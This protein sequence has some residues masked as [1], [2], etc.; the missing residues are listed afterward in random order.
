[1]DINTFDKNW[2]GFKEPASCQHYQTK[3]YG[4]T[5]VQFCTESEFLKMG[6]KE[7]TKFEYNAAKFDYIQPNVSV[8]VSIKDL[9]RRPKQ[10]YVLDVNNDRYEIAQRTLHEFA[11]HIAQNQK[12]GFQ[13]KP[14]NTTPELFVTPVSCEGLEEAVVK[15]YYN[16]IYVGPI[17]EYQYGFYLRLMCLCVDDEIFVEKPNRRTSTAKAK[18]NICRCAVLGC[19]AVIR[20][21]WAQF[22]NE[23]QLRVRKVNHSEEFAHSHDCRPAYRF[24]EELQSIPVP[25]KVKTY[26]QPKPEEFVHFS[27]DNLISEK[28][29][30]CPQT[31]F[32]F[33]RTNTTNVDGVTTTYYSCTKSDDDCPARCHTKTDGTGTL[34]AL[35]GGPHN[36][37]W[38]E[39]KQCVARFIRKRELEHHVVATHSDTKMYPCPQ[40]PKSYPSKKSLTKHQLGHAG[41]VECACGKTFKNKYNLAG[42]QKECKDAK[43]AKE[44]NEEI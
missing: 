32:K 27:D 38:L 15:T 4:S 6:F 26:I 14:N 18:E 2:F 30:I 36:H 8:S 10:M 13:A 9:K 21:I 11:Q 34:I 33:G 44:A 37:D 28:Q 12:I 17:S 23:I 19:K 31:G 29:I 39:C 42:H 5:T 1:M 43:D 35:L 41:R 3:E 7:I 24:E 25:E 40:C 22:N 16:E 20:F